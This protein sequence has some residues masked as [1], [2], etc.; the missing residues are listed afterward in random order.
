MR[1]GLGIAFVLVQACGGTAVTVTQS[2]EGSYDLVFSGVTVD[3]MSPALGPPGKPPLEGAHA[4]LDIRV[5]PNGYDAMIT[6]EWGSP[7]RYYVTAS[8]NQV[9]L[10]KGQSHFIQGSTYGSVDDTIDRVVL[11]RAGN[12]L[13]GMVT[14][15]GQEHVFQGDVGGDAAFRGSATLGK[16]TTA[17]RVRDDSYVSAGDRHLP[18]D[19]ISIDASEPLEE[20]A[21]RNAIGFQSVSW[22]PS[23]AEPWPGVM[24]IVGYATSFDAAGSVD[25]A[26]GLLDPSQNASAALSS[27]RKL[28]ELAPKAAS[29]TTFAKGAWGMTTIQTMP[30]CEA[31]G[32]LEIGPIQTTCNPPSAGFAARIDAKGKSKITIRWRVRS[33]GQG[34]RNLEVTLATPGTKPTVVEGHAMVAMTGDMKYPWASSWMSTSFDVM[35]DDDLGVGIRAANDGGCGGW[36]PQPQP[37]VYDIQSII[38]E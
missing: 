30:I 15:S 2:I 14:V 11:A 5:V 31:D 21:L 17:P 32:C 25:V 27:P 24:G 26:A 28:L 22:R 12:G 8:S 16:D 20:G 29:I 18:W 4:R 37:T 10:D 35:G 3:P 1:L 34:A 9:V 7:A 6:P 33:T 38:A 23:M 13:T 36:A 19:A